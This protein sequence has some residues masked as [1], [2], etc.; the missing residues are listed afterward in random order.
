MS[1]KNNVQQ[2]KQSKNKHATA[3]GSYN[4]VNMAGKPTGTCKQLVQ[5]D[6]SVH[7]NYNPVNMARKKADSPK[8]ITRSNS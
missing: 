4:P 3:V 1:D 7:D 5:E 6:E 2:Q 8:K